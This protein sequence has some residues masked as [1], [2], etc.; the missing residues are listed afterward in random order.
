MT[1]AFME[2]ICSLNFPSI[3]AGFRPLLHDLIEL[4][5]A[6][7]IGTQGGL[8]EYSLSG[9]KGGGQRFAAKSLRVCS[10]AK[11]QS[12]YRVLLARSKSVK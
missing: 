8:I 10:S 6:R 4:R 1:E 9:R 7:E 11:T 12:L 3:R 2:L 5:V